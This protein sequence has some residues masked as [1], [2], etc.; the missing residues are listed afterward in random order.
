MQNTYE[1]MQQRPFTSLAT[2][3]TTFGTPKL[4]EFVGDK[5]D[6]Q[7]IIGKFSRWMTRHPVGNQFRSITTQLV[8]QQINKGVSELENKI[9]GEPDPSE[10]NFTHAMSVV[11]SIRDNM[12]GLTRTKAIVKGIVANDASVASEALHRAWGNAKKQPYSPLYFSEIREA[13]N[14]K[15]DKAPVINSLIDIVGEMAMDPDNWKNYMLQKAFT[16]EADYVVNVFEDELKRGIARTVS[17]NKDPLSELFDNKT[18]IFNN[19]SPEVRRIIIQRLYNSYSKDG[20]GGLRK[21]MIKIM[22]GRNVGFIEEA[23]RDTE[24]KQLKTIETL[25]KNILSGNFVSSSVD[26]TFKARLQEQLNRVNQYKVLSGKDP[27]LSG[28]QKKFVEEFDDC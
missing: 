3:L 10:L 7:S 28:V 22:Q 24:A 19:V 17:G 26:A 14:I 1:S 16:E 12:S 25:F 27:K 15:F 13:A 5:T 20:S 8:S 9:L 11:G 21:E 6:T 18:G 2:I 23:M 4:L